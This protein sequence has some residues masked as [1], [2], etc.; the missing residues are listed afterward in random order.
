MDIELEFISS[1]VLNGKA[2]DEK[3]S[4]ILKKVRENKILIVEESLS[5]DERK[6]LM[7][8]DMAQ[9]DNEFTGIEFDTLGGDELGKT[10]AHNVKTKLIKLLGGK[11]GGLTVIGP[12][13]L[14]R[15]IKKHPQKISLLAGTRKE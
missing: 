13:K 2:G 3:I 8:A 4:Y 14:I 9:I 1:E 7:E 11:T 5:F 10:W 12:S 15:E 6:K